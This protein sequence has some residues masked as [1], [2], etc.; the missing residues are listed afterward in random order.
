MVATPR[1]RCLAIISASW[2]RKPKKSAPHHA[3]TRPATT[4][5][6]PQTELERNETPVAAAV[7]PAL[8]QPPSAARRRCAAA[9]RAEVRRLARACDRHRHPLALASGQTL[10]LARACGQQRRR[11]PDCRRSARTCDGILHATA[12]WLSRP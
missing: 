4:P 8:V 11:A 10:K 6:V 5:E 2:C 7:P 3:S 12:S 1:P 9:P